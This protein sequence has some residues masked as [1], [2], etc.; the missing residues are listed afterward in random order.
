MDDV[1][2]FIKENKFK[3]LSL[4][5][6]VNVII[7]F[8]VA[9]GGFVAGIISIYFLY[10]SLCLYVFSQLR[11]RRWET[12]VVFVLYIAASV[13]FILGF[14]AISMFNNGYFSIPE[15]SSDLLTLWKHFYFSASMFTSLGFSN[16]QPGN[17]HAEF[18][19]VAQCLLGGAHSVTFISII[20]MNSNWTS[21]TGGS[22]LPRIDGSIKQQLKLVEQI[23]KLV[24]MLRV[25]IALLL[26]IFFALMFLA[27]RV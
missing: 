18:F 23:P 7:L 25:V 4:L 15:Q 20:L 24:L 21:V 13:V 8:L 1:I 9:F 12:S 10:F 27:V 11:P 17:F 3:A 22:D 2:E 26:L 16:Y 6:V 14:A 5:V 19:V